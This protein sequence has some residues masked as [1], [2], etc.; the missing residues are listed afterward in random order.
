LTSTFVA[1]GRVLAHVLLQQIYPFRLPHPAFPAQVGMLAI[2]SNIAT[3]TGPML[4]V[5]L[6]GSPFGSDGLAIVIG[7]DQ[8]YDNP[9]YQLITIV[10]N[11]ADN[12]CAKPGDFGSALVLQGANNAPGVVMLNDPECGLIVVDPSTR[13]VVDQSTPTTNPAYQFIAE[14]GAHS[15]PIFDELTSNLYFLDFSEYGANFPRVCCKVMSNSQDCPG[16]GQTCRQIPGTGAYTDV[17]GNAV[18]GKW[19]FMSLA[20]FASVSRALP[21]RWLLRR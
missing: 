5:P 2:P 3:G 16:W 6:Q 19:T 10:G 9:P 7:L 20:F 15:H 11:S 21:H 13:L 17:L 8:T 1:V 18:Q 12:E 4:W 14:D